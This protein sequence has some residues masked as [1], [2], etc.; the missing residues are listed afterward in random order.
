MKKEKKE[1]MNIIAVDMGY[2]HQ[3]AAYPFLKNSNDGIINANKY[4]G[5][6]NKEKRIWRRNRK[7]YERISRFKKVPILGNLVFGLMIF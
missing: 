5:I 2:G 1:K 3:R 4:Q 7:W 6:S